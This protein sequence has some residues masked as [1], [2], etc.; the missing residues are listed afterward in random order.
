MAEPKTVRRS[1]GGFDHLHHRIDRED[2]TLR[3]D[4]GSDGQCWL[5][6][7]RSDIENSVAT[8]NQPIRDKRLRHGLKHLPDDFA[9][10]LPERR[11]ITPCAYGLLVGL[12]QQKYNCRRMAWSLNQKL[13]VSRA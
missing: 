7:T 1:T 3:A 13:L 12:H 10:L 4:Q 5:S 9:V 2:L 11:R 8:A 6:G